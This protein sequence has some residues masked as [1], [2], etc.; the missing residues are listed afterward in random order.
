MEFSSCQI[1]LEH[2]STCL[3]ALTLC[4][5]SDHVTGWRDLWLPYYYIEPCC[6]LVCKHSRTLFILRS[7]MTFGSTVGI[8]A[9]SGN[10]SLWGVAGKP[11]VKIN[12]QVHQC[13]SL[14]SNKLHLGVF[15]PGNSTYCKGDIISDKKFKNINN[16]TWHVCLYAWVIVCTGNQISLI[17]CPTVNK[18][19]ILN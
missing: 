6:S 17:G 14:I 13:V 4:P 2:I 11:L 9:V 5:R 7:P 8:V 16:K 12:P 10:L 18:S 15:Q 19:G 3:F 1:Q